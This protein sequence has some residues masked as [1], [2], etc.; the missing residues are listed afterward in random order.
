MTRTRADSP[1]AYRVLAQELRTAILQG[2]YNGGLRLPTEAELA[3][4]H[5]ISRQTVRRAFQDLVAEGVV[6]RVPGR[7]TF[8]TEPGG[9]YLRQF[10]SIDD[11]MSLSV[12]TEM[13]LLTP[14]ERQVDVA[15]AGRLQLEHDVVQRASFLRTRDG[16]PFCLTTVFLPA[17]IAAYLEGVP[18]LGKAG[19]VSTAT[20]IGLLDTRLPSP[21]A[22]ADQSITATTATA[23][24]AK[25]LPC[26]VGD[27][28]L[29]IDRLYLTTNGDPVELAISFFL[30][31]QYSYRL[32][33]RRSLP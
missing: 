25:V 17:Q 7:G 28:I 24:I 20:I 19:T 6:Y 21:I 3:Q 30:P 2:R 12:D 14:L 32:R 4:Q 22:D 10:G 29:R 13:R 15:A 23:R 9:R 11:L 27:P 33:L 18:E 1:A 8:V 5:S 16:A 26:E 31:D